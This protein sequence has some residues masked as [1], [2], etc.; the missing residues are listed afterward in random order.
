MMLEP[1]VRI[2]KP[3]LTTF[4]VAAAGA[5]LLLLNSACQQSYKLHHKPGSAAAIIAPPAVVTPPSASD[6]AVAAAI[7]TEATLPTSFH[8]LGLFTGPNATQPISSLVPYNVKV[9]LWSDGLGKT[10]FIYVPT[11]STISH[12]RSSNNLVFPKGT[13][14][15]KHF[16][17]GSTP[18]ET[19]VIVH[20]TDDSWKMA[21]YQWGASGD[22]TRV[23]APT[24]TTAAA[25]SNKGYRL[26][27][28]AE[29]QYCHATTGSPVLGFQPDQLNGAPPDS[30]TTPMQ[31][32]AAAPGLIARLFAPGVTDSINA[33][34]SR[35][36]PEDSTLSTSMRARA[37]MD[38]NCST[39]HNP[40]GMANFLDFTLATGLTTDY[41]SALLAFQRVVPG[42]LKSSIIWQKYTDPLY[43]MPPVSLYQDPL[44]YQLLHDW[45]SAWPVSPAAPASVSPSVPVAN[46]KGTAN[47]SGTAGTKVKGPDTGNS[48]G[49]A[50]G[51]GSGTGTGNMSGTGADN[52]SG[53]D[54]SN[55]S[56]TGAGNTSGTD[57]GNTSGTSAINAA[58]SGA[59]SQSAGGT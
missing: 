39:C 6:D 49:T 17:D 42:E 33:A 58:G 22:A 8:A 29:C 24:I 14:L 25:P 53:T 37:Y 47:S 35:P 9:S 40:K 36:D 19:R 3:F 20:S 30:N 18:I 10:R 34:P 31:S 41:P 38:L 52:A 1:A 43:R 23:D 4:S 28:P 21:T 46:G 54:S 56:G 45:L 2:C 51:N 44:G 7:S 16:T 5:T 55:T 57:A 26:P 11:G 27:S 32:L 13:I 48:G 15:I 59:G 12:E 50:A